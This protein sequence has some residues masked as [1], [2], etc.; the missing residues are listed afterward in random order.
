MRAAGYSYDSPMAPA[1]DP[2]FRG[3]LSPAETGTAVADVDCKGRTN[4]VGVWFTVESEYQ[5][6]LVHD[7]AAA[8]TLAAAAVRAELEVARR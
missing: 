8:L 2:R 7:H 4:L 3:P 6:P 1:A 5:R